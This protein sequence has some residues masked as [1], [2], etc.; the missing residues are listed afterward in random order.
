MHLTNNAN[1]GLFMNTSVY[2]VEHVSRI[3]FQSFVN[4]YVFVILSARKQ[5]KKK[6]KHTR[7]SLRKNIYLLLATWP[8]LLS[9]FMRLWPAETTATLK[10]VQSETKQHRTFCC[11]HKQSIVYIYF[12]LDNIS[13]FCIVLHF[14]ISLFTVKNMN[15]VC[16]FK[17]VI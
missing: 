8:F 1:A 9:Q 11:L 13:S 5:R 6:K 12:L 4:L 16:I 3:K 2:L 7:K 14:E 15:F 17:L 10:Y